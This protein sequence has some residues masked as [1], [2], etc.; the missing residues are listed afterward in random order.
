MMTDT[1]RYQ[2]WTDPMALYLCQNMR[3]SDAEEIFAQRDRVDP[4][5]LFCDMRMLRPASVWCDLV[6]PATAI[7]PVAIFGITLMS[8]GVGMAHMFGTDRLTLAQTRAIATRIREIVIPE[9]LQMGLHR[10]EALSLNNYKWAHRFL[11][12]AGARPEGPP[13]LAV[14]KDRQ[15]FQNFIWLDSWY[16]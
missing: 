2:G 7:Q 11:K 16:K 4:Y 9:M 6:Y 3:A 5:G 1:L 8:P 14:G 13:R 15:D 10:V 12:S